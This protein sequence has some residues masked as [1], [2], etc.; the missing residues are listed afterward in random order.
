MQVRTQGWVRQMKTI[1]VINYKGGVGKTTVVANIAAELAWRGERVLLI[2]LDPQ[3][4]LTFSLIDVVTWDNNYATSTTIRNWYDAYI[5]Q[6]Q[7]LELSS[8]IIRPSVINGL[9]DESSKGGV[10]DLICSHLSLINVDLE[11]AATGLGASTLRQFQNNFVRL[12]SRLLDGLESPSVQ[13]NYDYVIIDCP[14]NFNIVTKTAIVACNRI[15][16]P[17]FPDYLSTLG[18]DELNRHITGLVT[19]YNICASGP[20]GQKYSSIAPS[21]I[22]VIPTMVRIYAGEPIK[23]Q[24]AFIE[25]I[26]RNNVP[27]FDTFIRRID[28]SYG[29]TPEYGVPVVLKSIASGKRTIAEEEMEKLTAE[30]LQR[31]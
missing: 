18:I 4:S 30:F 11:L 1:A 25:R 27:V 12:H 19:E 13:E 7:N 20:G 9:V 10:V 3:A 31:I 2:D 23:A 8:L 29:P 15:L 5:D 14:P 26:R 22:G 24:A 17:A 6:N 21:V 16:I 28:T